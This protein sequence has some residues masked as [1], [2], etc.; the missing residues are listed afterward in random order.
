MDLIRCMP[1][2]P[3][4]RR[5]KPRDATLAQYPDLDLS[6]PV[7]RA[8]FEAGRFDRSSEVAERGHAT[9]RRKRRYA[10]T[11]PEVVQGEVVGEGTVVRIDGMTRTLPEGVTADD[12]APACTED[13]AQVCRKLLDDALA[14]LGEQ[15]RVPPG[16]RFL[17][18]M[19]MVWADPDTGEVERTQAEIASVLGVKRETLRDHLRRLEKAG[20][21][22]NNYEA[23]HRDGSFLVLNFHE[24]LRLSLDQRIA[25]AER[26]LKRRVIERETVRERI[27]EEYE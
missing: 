27:T 7:V 23:G 22:E 20:L 5:R 9:R 25:T 19:S 24:V 3:R 17:F 13:F 10:E 12:I 4:G 8:A 11:H 16:C 6:V 21:I 14:R 26:R 18:A 2:E 15:R 1:E